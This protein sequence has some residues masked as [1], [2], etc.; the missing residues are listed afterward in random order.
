MRKNIK[1]PDRHFKEE[2]KIT[3][4]K[5]PVDPKKQKEAQKNL[6]IT[7][8]NTIIFV[9]I[10]YYCDTIEF[11]P[12]IYIYLAVLTVTGLG[13]IIY[14]RGFSRE[15]VT[16]AM[17]PDSMSDEEKAEFFSSRDKRKQQSK[18]MLT[19]IIPCVIKFL[20]DMIGLFILPYL[21]NLI[22]A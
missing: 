11:Y 4:E 8:I 15:N 21:R 17:L 5:K 16:P 10:Y 19:I 1:K 9:G 7:F 14:N 20:L 6:I 2:E 22:G 3:R 13:Y 12:A 18:W